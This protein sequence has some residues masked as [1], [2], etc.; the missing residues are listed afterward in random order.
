MS[1]REALEAAGADVIEFQY[2][3]SYQGDWIA[4]VRWENQVVWVHG[5]YGSCSYCDAFEAE[6][7]Y[8]NRDCEEHRWM[9]ESDCPA[10]IEAMENYQKAMTAFGRHYLDSYLTQEEMEKE[11]GRNAEWSWEDGQM[12]T[13][14]QNNRIEE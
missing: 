1:Y 14:V 11:A 5:S 10:C 12:L 6:I 2:F 8:L 7:G 9:G 4:K 13:F 3:G